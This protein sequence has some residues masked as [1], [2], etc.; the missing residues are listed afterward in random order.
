MG[1]TYFWKESIGHVP[2][3]VLRLFWYFIE[4][5]GTITCEVIGLRKHGIGL[6]VPCTYNFSGKKKIIRQQCKNF[7]SFVGWNVGTII[8]V[9]IQY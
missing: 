6:E 9:T 4:H 7:E 3:E 5:D 8:N 2:R 1:I